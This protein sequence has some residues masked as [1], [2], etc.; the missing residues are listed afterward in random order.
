MHKSQSVF[1]SESLNQAARFTELG[2]V[3]TQ[4]TFLQIFDQGVLRF[5]LGHG[6]VIKGWDLG[7]VGITVNETRKLVIPSRLAYGEYSASCC[8]LPV[9]RR[10]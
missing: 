6:H 2:S 3:L 5:P 4:A 10:R 1:D 7:L 9:S 8:V